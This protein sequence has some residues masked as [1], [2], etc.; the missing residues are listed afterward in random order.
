M[1]P[2][3]N[4]NKQHETINETRFLRQRLSWRNAT[5]IKSAQLHNV[6]YV[7]SV[8]KCLE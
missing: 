1:L 4:N 2:L 8:M 3:Y 5:D 7:M 6:R